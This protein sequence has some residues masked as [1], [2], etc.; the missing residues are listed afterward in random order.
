[1]YQ[2]EKQKEGYA[3]STSLGLHLPSFVWA[4]TIPVSTL[5]VSTPWV[6]TLSSSIVHLLVFDR[7]LNMLIWT[8]S[9]LVLFTALHSFAWLIGSHYTVNTLNLEILCLSEFSRMPEFEAVNLRNFRKI[10]SLFAVVSSFTLLFT[11]P[12]TV[13]FASNDGGPRC[14]PVDRDSPDLFGAVW[15]FHLKFY[16][17]S[18]F[19]FITNLES[20]SKVP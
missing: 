17:E 16:F 6:F 20:F 1:M 5:W 2:F 9:P 14:L 11:I 18:I 10:T 19:L 8:W 12:F 4:Q 7:L 15:I 13:I 3:Q